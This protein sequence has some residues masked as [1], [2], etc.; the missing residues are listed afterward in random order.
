VGKYVKKFMP[1][2]F[3]QWVQV[4]SLLVGI[5]LVANNFIN[6]FGDQ[7]DALDRRVTHI[8]YK[9]KIRN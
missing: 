3:L 6:K 9:I 2:T 5:T 7:F 4:I 8:E 1:E